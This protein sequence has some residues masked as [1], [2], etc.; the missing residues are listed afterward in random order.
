MIWRRQ[1]ALV[2]VE[3]EAGEDAVHAGRD[4]HVDDRHGREDELETPELG[5]R[6]EVGVER[7]EEERERLEQRTRAAV[8]DGVAR[9][10][11]D[12]EAA[13]RVVVAA[14][15]DLGRVDANVRHGLHCT[16]PDPRGPSPP[17]G[18]CGRGARSGAARYS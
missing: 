9:E 3:V 5:R 16:V 8:D 11:G 7:D 2:A 10:R 12:A 15:L 17:S 18:A 14:L 6:D 1:P 4:E 13:G